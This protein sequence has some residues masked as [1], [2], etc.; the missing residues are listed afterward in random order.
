MDDKEISFGFLGLEDIV[1]FPHAF[2]DGASKNNSGVAGVGGSIHDLRGRQV[3]HYA[4]GL[5]NVSKNIAKDHSFRCGHVI[6][7]EEGI[8]SLTVLRDSMLVIRVVIDHANLR[9]EN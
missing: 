8:K 9:G 7:K 4:L 6:V 5:G 1:V 2:L 3:D